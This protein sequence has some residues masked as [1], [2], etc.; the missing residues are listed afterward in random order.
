MKT[1]FAWLPLLACMLVGCSSKPAKQPD[2][3]ESFQQLVAELKERAA[4]KTS[5]RLSMSVTEQV[6]SNEMRS[7]P[8]TRTIQV[9]KQTPGDAPGSPAQTT[10]VIDL[11]FSYED[12]RWRCS[13][14]E[15]KEFDGDKVVGQNSLGGPD[16]RFTNLFPWIGL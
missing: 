5:D 2:A 9:R 11:Y 12:G 16:I 13:R 8:V 3:R 7:E 6:A 1:L 15:S 14:A 10:E 4:K